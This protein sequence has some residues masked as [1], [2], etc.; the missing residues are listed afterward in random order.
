MTHTVLLNKVYAYVRLHQTLFS[1]PFHL[2]TPSH[3]ANIPPMSRLTD[4]WPVFVC[5]AL[6]SPVLWPNTVANRPKECYFVSKCV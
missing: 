3:P 6:I 4:S 1:F 5:V 2:K